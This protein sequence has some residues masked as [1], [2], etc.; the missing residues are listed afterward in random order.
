[1]RFQN[2]F[3][4]QVRVEFQTFSKC[5]TM[6]AT[7]QKYL[8]SWLQNKQNRQ[9]KKAKSDKRLALARDTRFDDLK[10]KEMVRVDKAQKPFLSPKGTGVKQTTAMPYEHVSQDNKTSKSASDDNSAKA[11]RSS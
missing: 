7:K 5:R 11:D 9:C 4:A 2:N 6:K 3:V 1:M 10:T 8:V